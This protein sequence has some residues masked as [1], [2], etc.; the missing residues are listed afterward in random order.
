[1]ATQVRILKTNAKTS[2]LVRS[3]IKIA[4][5]E[6]AAKFKPESLLT[7]NDKGE[8]TYAIGLG[9]VASA[10]ELGLIIPTDGTTINFEVTPACMPARMYKVV[11]KQIQD[12]LT[13]LEA[14]AG[15]FV[16][17]VDGAQ[18]EEV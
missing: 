12:Q 14:I 10:S 13:A 1:M 18:L 16:A 2:L 17:E 9:K 8:I 3:D 11:G 6:I 15:T 4:D 7:R 5:L